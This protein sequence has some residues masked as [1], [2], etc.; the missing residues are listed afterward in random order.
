[1]KNFDL[2]KSRITL[3]QVEV[4]CHLNKT[5]SISQTASELNL[6]AAIVSQI[7]SRF[8][9]HF[10]FPIFAKRRKGV[11]L[12][13]EGARI[14]AMIAPLGQELSRLSLNLANPS[15]LPSSPP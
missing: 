4:I 1:M 7:C 6:S 12:T 3:R 14:L 5:L 2:L 9:A 10:D 8:E 11:S 13:D 15:S